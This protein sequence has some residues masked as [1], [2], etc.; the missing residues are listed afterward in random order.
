MQK[1]K[2]GNFAGIFKAA[3]L[4]SLI[5]LFLLSIKLFGSSFEAMGSSAAEAI[6][7]TV[8]N[9]FIG[10]ITGILTTA[11]VQSSSMTTSL[12]VGFVA[13]GAFGTDSMTAIKLAIPIIMGANI[14]TSVTNMLVSYGHVNDSDEFERAFSTS[15]VH[16]FFNVLSVLV[17][18]PLQYFFNMLGVMANLLSTAFVGIGG[19]KLFN[20]IGIII[21]PVAKAIMHYIPVPW[22]GILV[23]LFL[24]FLALRYIVK[25]M[26][27]MVLEKIEILFDRYI[28]KTTLRALVLGMIFTA[29]VQS[30][31]ITTS[32]AVPLAAAGV[33]TISQVYPYALGAN[34]GTTI[35]ALLAAL[36]TGHPTA[37]TIAFSHLIF[38]LLGISI[39]L[40]LKKIPITMAVKFAEWSKTRKYLPA[41]YILFI[42][43]II[44][45]LLIYIL[46]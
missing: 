29:I 35:T 39:F 11:L 44:P 37:V 8:S 15:V 40:P 45:G 43:F 33:I 9:P 7:Q 25:V 30:S 41:L 10:L 17:L 46:R 5:Y 32:L 2:P 6:M 14:G 1:F 38:N 22:L 31:S 3:A 18:F 19:V 34:I 42:F 36:S 12:V 28:F 24:L 27:M 4:L 23:S 16:D 21:K 13:G 26:K 20:P